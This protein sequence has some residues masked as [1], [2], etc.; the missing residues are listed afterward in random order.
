MK[1]RELILVLAAIALS[2]ICF[3]VQVYAGPLRSF[4]MPADGP[5][6]TVR[7]VDEFVGPTERNVLAL[8]A[9]ATRNRRDIVP[10]CC[11]ATGCYCTIIGSLRDFAAL[12]CGCE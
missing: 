7:T 8:W 6:A 5:V 10:A 12:Q 3:V 9:E 11:D 2:I 4:R 1:R